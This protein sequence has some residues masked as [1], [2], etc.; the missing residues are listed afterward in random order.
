MSAV[1]TT[2]AALRE[3]FGPPRSELVRTGQWNAVGTPASKA[4]TWNVLAYN[5]DIPSYTDYLRKIQRLKRT[6]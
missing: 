1:P 5:G 6:P 2:E 4:L 3:L